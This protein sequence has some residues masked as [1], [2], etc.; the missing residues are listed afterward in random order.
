MTQQI[1]FDAV[2]PAH[3][4]IDARLRNWARWVKG[5]NGG[6][7]VHPMF[8]QYRPDNWER[9]VSAH[10]PVDALRAA[11][12]QKAVG[13]LPEKNRHALGWVYVIGGSP[14]QQ[15]QKLAVSMAGLYGLIVDGRQMLI[16]RGA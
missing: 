11:D 4:D 14:R 13:K 16:N 8:R 5:G 1:D 15:A 3:R 10:E 2:S 12:M 6:R 9:E 7:D